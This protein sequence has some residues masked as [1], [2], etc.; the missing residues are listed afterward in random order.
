M[1]PESLPGA[2]RL[3]ERGE[4]LAHRGEHRGRRV[5]E[6]AAGAGIGL[7]LI[8][9]RLSALYGDA[10]RLETGRSPLGGFRAAVTVP[11]GG[12]P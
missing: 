1:P 12:T 11:I 2:E 5:D 7:R 3:A 8:R 9:D 4:A 6:R 10:A